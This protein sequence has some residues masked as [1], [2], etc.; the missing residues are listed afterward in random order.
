MYNIGSV[1]RAAGWE[2]YSLVVYKYSNSIA[3]LTINYLD[4]IIIIII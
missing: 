2:M 3:S 4:C 1:Y